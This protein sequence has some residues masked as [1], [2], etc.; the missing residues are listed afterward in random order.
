MRFQNREISLTS[1][2]TSADPNLPVK[3]LG[4]TE[5][6]I[7]RVSHCLAMRDRTPWQARYRSIWDGFTMSTKVLSTLRRHLGSRDGRTCNV[8]LQSLSGYLA[9]GFAAPTAT[10]PSS[11]P[12]VD[13]KG[14]SKRNCLAH[15]QIGSNSAPLTTNV[16]PRRSDLGT[17]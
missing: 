13:D 12:S 8:R 9:P 3:R 11:E 16:Y 10:Q 14:W 5:G 1:R 17:T 7:T 4:Y 2:F 15:T 6:S